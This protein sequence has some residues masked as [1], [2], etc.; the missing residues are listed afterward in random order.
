MVRPFCNTS[1]CTAAAIR[2]LYVVETTRRGCLEPL[3]CYWDH[4]RERHGHRPVDKSRLC[5]LINVMFHPGKQER[6]Y[7][8]QLSLHHTRRLARQHGLCSRR[9]LLSPLNATVPEISTKAPHIAHPRP[10]WL[11][12]TK[13]ADHLNAMIV[14]DSQ[15]MLMFSYINR[16]LLSYAIGWAHTEL[17]MTSFISVTKITICWQTTLE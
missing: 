5:H 2:H 13:I 9:V 11:K 15:P 16:S 14:S 6:P 10:P 8:Q 3:Q 7:V 1:S 17:G 4:C 12:M